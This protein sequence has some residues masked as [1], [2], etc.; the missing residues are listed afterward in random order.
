MNIV[1]ALLHVFDSHSHWINCQ[2]SKW[3]VCHHSMREYWG[4]GKGMWSCE[5]NEQVSREAIKSKTRESEKESLWPLSSGGQCFKRESELNSSVIL[6]LKWERNTRTW[7]NIVFDLQQPWSWCGQCSSR[8]SWWPACWGPP[9]PVHG[10]N[11]RMTCFKVT[12]SSPPNK[13]PSRLFKLHR[14]DWC[15]CS[16]SGCFHIYA[17]KCLKWLTSMICEITNSLV[18]YICACTENGLYNEVYKM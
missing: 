6:K 13:I 10:H 4:Q 15:K 11:D 12:P 7:T 9:A 16:R 1:L 8:A 5:Y 17:W 14:A 18:M 3:P 2:I